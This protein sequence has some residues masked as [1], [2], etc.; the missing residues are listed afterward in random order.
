M[1]VLVVLF[2]NGCDEMRMSCVVV[3][4]RTVHPVVQDRTGGVVVD[5]G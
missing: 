4:D 2:L 5:G 3:M 1:V